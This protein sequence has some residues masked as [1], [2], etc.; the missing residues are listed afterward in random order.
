MNQPIRRLSMLVALMFVLLLGASTWIQVLGSQDINLFRRVVERIREKTDLILS[1][2]TS[3]IPGRPG[4]PPSKSPR[5]SSRARV[6]T[7]LGAALGLGAGARV[8]VQ[9]VAAA[10]GLG[11]GPGRAEQVRLGPGVAGLFAEERA[12]EALLAGLLLGRGGLLAG[13]RVLP[14]RHRLGR[15]AGQ[16]P[17]GLHEGTLARRV[18]GRAHHLPVHVHH[19]VGEGPRLQPRP[20]VLRDHLRTEVEV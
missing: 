1:L 13:G 20:A 2:T 9:A 3:G 8:L 15:Q 10:L 19:D 11:P 5:N 16:A 12:L 7:S 4:A 14:G 17:G 18:L 6:H